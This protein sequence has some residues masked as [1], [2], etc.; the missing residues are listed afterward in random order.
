MHCP[1]CNIYIN[2]VDSELVAHFRDK[3]G[4]EGTSSWH[5]LS[6]LVDVPWCKYRIYRTKDFKFTCRCGEVADY[7][8]EVVVD[9][10]ISLDAKGQAAHKSLKERKPN[11]QYK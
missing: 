10:L 4:Q 9:H 8:K 3:K 6:Y 5:I 2:A 7:E 1:K 11:W